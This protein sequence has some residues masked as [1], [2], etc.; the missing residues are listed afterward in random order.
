MIK[1]KNSNLINSNDKIEFSDDYKNS[2]I[3][4]LKKE[5]V[6]LIHGLLKR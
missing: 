6:Y 2:K 1:E 5:D 3:S 4:Y